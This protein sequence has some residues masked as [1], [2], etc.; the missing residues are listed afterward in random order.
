MPALPN[1][2]PLSVALL[3]LLLAGT[4]SVSTTFV[5]DFMDPT[6]RTPDELAGYLGAPVLG[7]ILKG[8]D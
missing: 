4:V 8:G 7:A 6:F 1:R 2:S 5:A 3:T